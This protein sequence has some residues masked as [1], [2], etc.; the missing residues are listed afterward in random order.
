MFFQPMRGKLHQE[1]LTE[2]GSRRKILLKLS[3][4]KTVA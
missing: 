4:S 2:N 3:E 1:Q